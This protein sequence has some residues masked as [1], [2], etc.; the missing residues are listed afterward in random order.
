MG[1][2]PQLPNPLNE[3]T[4]MQHS[5]LVDEKYTAIGTHID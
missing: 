4:V 3:L 2:L 5:T 1:G